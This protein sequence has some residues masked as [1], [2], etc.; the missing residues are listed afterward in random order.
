M[1]I[2][3]YSLKKDGNKNIT[4]NIKVRELRCKDGTDIIK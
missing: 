4:P 1:N 2:K 3:K